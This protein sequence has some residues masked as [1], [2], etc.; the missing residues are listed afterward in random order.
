MGGVTYLDERQVGR[1]RE[2]WQI[3]MLSKDILKT[4]CVFEVHPVNHVMDDLQLIETIRAARPSLGL[5][6]K[7]ARHGRC[8]GTH[9]SWAGCE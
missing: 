5:R 2:H 6:N 7:L 4:V 3:Y 8:R 1:Q 9:Q